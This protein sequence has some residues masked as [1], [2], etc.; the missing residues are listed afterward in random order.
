MLAQ[1]KRIASFFVQHEDAIFFEGQVREIPKWQQWSQARFV[2]GEWPPL[3]L[4]STSAAA[5]ATAEVYQ[6]VSTRHLRCTCLREMHLPAC[7]A[8]AS[9]CDPTPETNTEASPLVE[10][11]A[12]TG[13]RRTITSSHSWRSTT[14]AWPAAC[15]PTPSAP[16]VLTVTR[17]TSPGSDDRS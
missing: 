3:I 5:K 9:A 14:A 10:R 15:S 6:N 7:I 4:N 1:A 13:R 8:F 2:S 16:S 11:R 12:G 17:P